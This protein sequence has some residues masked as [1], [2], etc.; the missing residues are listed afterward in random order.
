MLGKIF[1]KN[2]GNSL[3]CKDKQR[4]PQSISLYMK[5]NRKKNQ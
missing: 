2:D 4:D 1:N 3:G 5:H